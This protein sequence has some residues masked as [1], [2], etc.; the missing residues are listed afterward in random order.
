[1]DSRTEIIHERSDDRGAFVL[2]SNGKR[3]GRL[4]Y[5]VAGPHITLDHT[6]VEDAFRRTGAGAKLVNAAVEW[7]R[8]EHH[9]LL[10]RCSFTRWVFDKTPAYA[11]V[12]ADLS[13][14]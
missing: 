3:L 6:Y 1:M 8:A 9:R 10:P 11:D 4:T 2:I 13:K 14:K 7:A 5:T 12:R